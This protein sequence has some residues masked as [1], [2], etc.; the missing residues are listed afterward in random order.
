MYERRQ[1]FDRGLDLELARNS[2]TRRAA[3]SN[4]NVLMSIG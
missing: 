1:L 4:H 3:F 2:I